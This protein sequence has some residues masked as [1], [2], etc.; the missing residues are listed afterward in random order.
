M[1]DNEQKEEQLE[2]LDNDAGIVAEFWEFLQTNKKFWLIPLLL[3][4]LLMGLLLVLG[5]SSASPFIYTLF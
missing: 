2:N 1:S 3:I 4:L 5:S